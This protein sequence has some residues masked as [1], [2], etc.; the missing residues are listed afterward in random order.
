MKMNEVIL[1]VAVVVF[2][3]SLCTIESLSAVSVLG[4]IISGAVIVVCSFLDEQ[5]RIREGR[6]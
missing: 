5:K 6:F 4:M 1:S 2:V 3:L